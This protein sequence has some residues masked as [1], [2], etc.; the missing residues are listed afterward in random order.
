MRRTS[1]AIIVAVLGILTALAA[2]AATPAQL[3]S[4]DEA[5]VRAAIARGYDGYR[6]DG[7]AFE[8]SP[9]FQRAWDRALGG[10]DLDFDPF[11]GCQE[12]IRENKFR[13]RIVSLS[14]NGSNAVANV[15]FDS[16]I[17]SVP[18]VSPWVHY[19]LTF[20]RTPQGWRLDDLGYP[21]EPSMK[22]AMMRDKP[23]SWGL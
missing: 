18:G 2:T 20:A 3:T 17:P 5:A 10:G 15:D 4:T 13:Y 6:T 9:D 8:L 7:E 23:G 21:T 16:G 12:S 11:C 1:T 22:A 14:V 19:R